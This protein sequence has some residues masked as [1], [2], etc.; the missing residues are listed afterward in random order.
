MSTGTPLPSQAGQRAHPSSPPA[1][2]A[3]GS[4]RGDRVHVYSLGRG[5]HVYVHST[6]P[7]SRTESKNE[8]DIP[9]SV[10]VS[11]SVKPLKDGQTAQLPVNC[12]LLHV[13]G[14]LV[15]QTHF[16]TSGRQDRPQVC[17]A[18]AGPGEGEG[19][20]RASRSGG[21]SL[22]AHLCQHP[23]MASSLRAG[24]CKL[25]FCSKRARRIPRAEPSWPAGPSGPVS[26]WTGADHS[27]A[28]TKQQRTWVWAKMS[29]FPPPGL[30]S[31]KL[32]RRG[33]REQMA[34]AGVSSS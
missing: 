19:H 18:G 22:D 23:R 33:L 29:G 16:Q 24:L 25:S 32:L 26:P 15:R 30:R 1:S 21:W 11:P 34:V 5:C 10:A 6:K 4:C 9:M 17:T 2:A 31:W 3:M 8:A 12:R 28:T 20:T 14:A 13:K 27:F 7:R